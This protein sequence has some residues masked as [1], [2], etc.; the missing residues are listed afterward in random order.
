VIRL[1]DICAVAFLITTAVKQISR[2]RGY[3]QAYRRLFGLYIVNAD[4][5]IPKVTDPRR[6]GKKILVLIKIGSNQNLIQS[7]LLRNKKRMQNTEKD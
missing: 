4:L 5:G 3:N 6:Y 1:R 2:E 7:A